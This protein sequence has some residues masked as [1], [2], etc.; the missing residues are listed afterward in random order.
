VTEVGMYRQRRPR[1]ATPPALYVV[2][3][4]KSG[5]RELSAVERRLLAQGGQLL[6][7][8]KPRTG[9]S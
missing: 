3:P 1:P 9:F 2:V 8:E 6:T 5:D 7:I 4:G